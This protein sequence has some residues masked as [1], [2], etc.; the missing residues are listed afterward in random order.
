M[1]TVERLEAFL[2]RSL[3]PG[4][5]TICGYPVDLEDSNGVVV[6]MTAVDIGAQRGLTK[7]LRQVGFKVT[8]LGVKD[9]IVF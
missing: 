2:G 7:A 5:N 6:A 9:L 8:R 1:T 4:R 3:T